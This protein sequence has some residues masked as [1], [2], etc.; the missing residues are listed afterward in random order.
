MVAVKKLQQL[1]KERFASDQHVRR[2]IWARQHEE[3]R[4]GGK[5]GKLI[6]EPVRGGGEGEEVRRDGVG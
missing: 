2:K 4:G 5:R 3:E 1:H 6:E